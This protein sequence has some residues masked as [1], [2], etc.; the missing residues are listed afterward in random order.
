MAAGN[1]TG[2]ATAEL[3][4]AI[5][6]QE[7]SC[8]ARPQFLVGDGGESCGPMHMKP[9]TANRFLAECGLDQVVT[10]GWLV[11][12]ANWNDAICL[13][14]Q[15]LNSLVD[16]CGTNIQDLAAGY[17]GGPGACASSVSCSSDTSCSGNPVKKWECL[18]DDGAH[19]QCNIG[20]VTTR[21]YATQV[22]Y[23]TLNPVNK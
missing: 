21:N 15:Y 20:Y 17:N 16:A 23:C 5:I 1:A 18:Y 10:C 8:A 19:Q 3:I 4:R 9:A 7:S 12:K 11:D 14:A 6:L 13:G 22:N 2:V